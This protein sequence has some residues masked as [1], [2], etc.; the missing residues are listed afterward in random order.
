MHG[1]EVTMSDS[2]VNLC[3]YWKVSDIGPCV[4]IH[5]YWEV[6]DLRPKSSQLDACVQA[7]AGAVISDV[8]IGS[9]SASVGPNEILKA[10]PLHPTCLHLRCGLGISNASNVRTGIELQS[11]DPIMCD[12]S[13]GA[14]A[15]G[16]EKSDVL[17]S[18]VEG[19]ETCDAV[20][21]ES[22][23]PEV[24][25][26]T[27]IV[28]AGADLLAEMNLCEVPITVVDDMDSMGGKATTI[29]ASYLVK[30]RGRPRK[31][32]EKLQVSDSLLLDKDPYEI[33]KSIWHMGLQLGVSGVQDENTVIAKLTD[34]ETRDRTTIGRSTGS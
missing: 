27:Q 4:E 30:R 18:Q 34:M 17:T 5:K 12:G 3:K 31:H 11:A 33:A 6:N 20:Q 8:E 26:E 32:P 16:D 29:P 23:T 2:G 15:R 24:V 21:K 22:S 28:G 14:I 10:T 9:C 7:T 13:G 25:L 1:V 19:V